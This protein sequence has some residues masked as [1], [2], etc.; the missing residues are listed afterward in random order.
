MSSI[1]Q[2]KGAWIALVFLVIITASAA[3]LSF[4]EPSSASPVTTRVL[5][6]GDTIPYDIPL[7]GT[8]GTSGSEL[9]AFKGK[10]VLL[11]FWAGWCGPCLKEMPS[12]YNLHDKLSGK[13]L[14]VIGLNMDESAA[15]GLAMLEKVA[16]K[17]APFPQFSAYEQDIFTRFPVEGLPLTVVIDRKGK[18]V[19]ARPGERNWME[20]SA[21][22]QLE[23]LL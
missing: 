20:P 18:I 14:A 1:Y 17:K 6:E 9:S 23:E 12:L 19:Y 3:V 8:P 16:G 10:V 5:G 21:L 4:R 13:G 22:A 11:N 7:V 2:K 15:D